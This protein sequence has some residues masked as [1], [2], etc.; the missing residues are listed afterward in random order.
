MALRASELRHLVPELAARLV[1]QPLSNAWQPARDHV[2]LGFLDGTRLLLVPRGPDARLHTVRRRPRNP[3]RPFSFQ[4]AMRAHLS[5]RLTGLVLHPTDRVV[6]LHFGDHRLHLRLTGNSGGLWL[7]HDDRVLAAYDG[8]APDALVPLA[9][10]G[11][12]DLPPRV[13]PGADGSWDDALARFYAHRIR[14]RRLH[15]LRIVVGRALRTE[16]KRLGRLVTN[17]EDDLERAGRADAIRDQA[18]TLAAYLHTVVAGADHVVLPA[19]D[20]SGDVRIPLRVGR[21]PSASLTHLYDKSRRLARMGEQVLDRLDRAE[22]D[23]ARAHEQLERVDGMELDELESLHQTTRG[24]TSPAPRKLPGVTTWTGPRGEQVLVGR[25][26]KANRRLSFQ[27]GR[28]HDYWMH[29]RG[30]PGSHL[31]L[32]LQRGQTPS[33]ELLLAAA[34]IAAVHGQVPAGARAEVQ[35]TRIRDIRSIPGSSDAKVRVF[36]EKVLQVVR[37]PSELSGWVRA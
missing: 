11:P 23:L 17:L 10:Y 24:T 35:Y 3:P 27:V 12:K 7:L 22:R 1:G 16:V 28:G 31:L 32:P 26:A 34:Q 18:D 29:L 13:A 37:D 14:E 2:L 21:S 15:E 19:L 9:P 5:G 20:G 6:D 8:P 30:R 36:N 33:L 25:D 4:G